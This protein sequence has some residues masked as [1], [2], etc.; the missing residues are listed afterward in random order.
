MFWLRICP[1]ALTELPRPRTEVVGRLRYVDGKTAL[2]VNCSGLHLKEFRTQ[3]SQSSSH[4]CVRWCRCRACPPGP[5]H[6]AEGPV[7]C[8]RAGD[9]PAM[10]RVAEAKAEASANRDALEAEK[11]VVERTRFR[12]KVCIY[13]IPSP[14][15]LKT[16]HSPLVPAGPGCAPAEFVVEHW[17]GVLG[18]GATVRGFRTAAKK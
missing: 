4:R 5:W 3:M 12:L 2:L 9:Q 6:P 14:A 11:C 15:N 1:A 7:A 17:A 13:P 8:P 10:L 16:D 18:S